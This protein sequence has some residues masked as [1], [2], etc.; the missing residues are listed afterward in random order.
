MLEENFRV[1]YES[2]LL[3]V[4]EKYHVMSKIDVAFVKSAFFANFH[5]K[6]T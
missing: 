4:L 5:L 1:D 6:I 3:F 2:T